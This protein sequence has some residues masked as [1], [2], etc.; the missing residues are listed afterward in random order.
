M[1]SHALVPKVSSSSTTSTSPLGWALATWGLELGYRNQQL[2]LAS[3]SLSD[4]SGLSPEGPKGPA[5]RLHSEEISNNEAVT[6]DPLQRQVLEVGGALLQQ[7][8]ISKKAS[9]TKSSE[10]TPLVL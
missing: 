2:P 10:A 9:A 6:M 5:D 4:L 3:P 8:G 7:M 1:T